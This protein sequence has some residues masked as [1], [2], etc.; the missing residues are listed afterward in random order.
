MRASHQLS[1]RLLGGK[2]QPAALQSIRGFRLAKVLPYNAVQ[3][4]YRLHG[5][6]TVNAIAHGINNGVAVASDQLDLE[7]QHRA[8]A[9]TADNKHLPAP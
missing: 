6:A 4:A 7:A 8:C 9:E 5:S 1:L 2:V 3:E